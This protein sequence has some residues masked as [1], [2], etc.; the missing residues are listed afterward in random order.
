[1]KQTSKLIINPEFFGASSPCEKL[2]HYVGML[3]GN[4]IALDGQ[5]N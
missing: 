5:G 3:D 1:V 4:D 2:K